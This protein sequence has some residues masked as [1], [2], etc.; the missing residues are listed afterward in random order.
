ME[1]AWNDLHPI[2]DPADD[3]LTSQGSEKYKTPVRVR[4]GDSN[5]YGGAQYPWYLRIEFVSCHPSRDLKFEVASRFSKNL[6]HEG[7]T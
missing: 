7:V 5:F 4:H 1:Q 3:Y 2:F 6:H